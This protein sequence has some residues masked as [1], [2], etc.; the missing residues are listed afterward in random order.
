MKCFRGLFI[1]G[2]T[3]D[4]KRFAN[5]YMVVNADFNKYGFLWGE[6]GNRDL[7]L[8]IARGQTHSAGRSAKG[9]PH[10]SLTPD[11]PV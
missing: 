7:R 2:S 1:V 9:D 10:T 6:Q 3:H 8:S 5:G 4:Q 11:S